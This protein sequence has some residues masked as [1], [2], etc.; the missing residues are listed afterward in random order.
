MSKQLDEIF[1]NM[2]EDSTLWQMGYNSLDEAK[3]TLEPYKA[4][5]QAYIEK[6][7]I[8]K[9]EFNR[10]AEIGVKRALKRNGA[11]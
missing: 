11:L 2:V 7:Y 3:Q 6:N 5:M 8:L 1:N 4:E 9:S 10:L